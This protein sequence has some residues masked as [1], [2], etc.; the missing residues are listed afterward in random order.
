MPPSKNLPR[1]LS[2]FPRQTGTE[3]SSQ[4]AFSQDISS[5][6]E[7]GGGGEDCVVEKITKINKGIG[8]KFW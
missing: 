5:W 7:R 3:H 1:I 8:R 2:L 4:T 6:A